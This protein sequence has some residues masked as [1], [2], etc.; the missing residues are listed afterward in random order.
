MEYKT[1][2]KRSKKT[3]P[4]SQ[5]F[6]AYPGIQLQVYPFIP[7]MHAPPF[8]QGLEAHSFSSTEKYFLIFKLSVTCSIIFSYFYHFLDSYVVISNLFYRFDSS[9][10]HTQERNCKYTH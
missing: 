1:V 6:P 3:L 7:S 4:V 10:P 9:L 5:S 2:N 8:R